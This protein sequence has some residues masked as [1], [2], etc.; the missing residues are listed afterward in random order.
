M[1]KQTKE[2]LQQAAYD[3]DTAQIMR[4]SKRNVYAIL[5]CHMAI[6]KALKGLV[7]QLTEEIPPKTHSLIYLLKKT[8]MKPGK[9]LGR[10]IIQLNDASV[11]TRYPEELHTLL[12]TYTDN[13]TDA[14]ITKT[15]E[16]MAWIKLQ[17]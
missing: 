13:L 12:S 14:I 2:W 11:A 8:K 6:E 10:F 7:Y 3:L 5:M 1:K 17:L 9:N 4:Q 16:T 15:E